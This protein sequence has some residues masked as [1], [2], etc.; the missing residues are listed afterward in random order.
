MLTAFLSS[1]VQGT[2]IHATK[3]IPASPFLSE[4]LEKTHFYIITNNKPSTVASDR[5]KLHSFTQLRRTHGNETTPK[6]NKD[7]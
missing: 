4:G 1:Y 6:Q 3:L 7:M 5:L 2:Y